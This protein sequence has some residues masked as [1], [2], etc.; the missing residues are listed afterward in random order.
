MR[1]SA[2]PLPR[3]SGKHSVICESL[4]VGLSLETGVEAE[5]GGEGDGCT[6]GRPKSL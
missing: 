6:G 3:G 1:F 2:V 5:R 4:C